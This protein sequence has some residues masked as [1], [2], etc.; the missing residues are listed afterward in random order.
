MYQK[1]KLINID[2]KIDKK[3]LSTGKKW[4]N[5]EFDNLGK[6]KNCNLLQKSWK[7]LELFLI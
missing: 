2:L 3:R 1:F 5:L 4:K 6:K 7:N